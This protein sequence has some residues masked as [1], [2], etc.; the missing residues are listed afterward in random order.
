MNGIVDKF[1]GR[2]VADYPMRGRVLEIGSLDICGS[3]R[4]WF[5]EQATEGDPGA[6]PYPGS[7]RWCKPTERFPEYIGIDHRDGNLVER[8]MEGSEIVDVFGIESF[9]VVISASAMEHDRE[10]WITMQQIAEVL[11]PSGWLILTAPSW[12][13]EPPHD[14]HDYWRFM[15]EGVQ[16]LIYRNA[17]NIVELL[18]SINSNDILCLAQKP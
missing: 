3:A 16:S 17:L 13:G 6:Y 1:I 2:V 12:R 15:S 10:F 14:Q 5:V 9:D 11:K 8:V 7:M 4:H 18:D